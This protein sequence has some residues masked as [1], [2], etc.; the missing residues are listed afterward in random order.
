L[1]YNP[2]PMLQASLSSFASGAGVLS[3]FG[4]PTCA[5][6]SGDRSTR[7]SKSPAAAKRQK[8]QHRKSGR[9]VLLFG[10]FWELALYRAEVLEAH[11][12]TVTLPR[13]K[14]DA[15]AAIRGGS[16]DIAILSY[17]LPDK[18][19]EELTELIREYCPECPLIAISDTGRVDRR[20]GPDGVVIADEGPAALIAALR[21]AIKSN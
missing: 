9:R 10:S 20:I 2:R 15:V 18:T 5:G 17:T 6:T 13:T 19:V 16:F 4:I 8:P 7:L 12:F 1:R 11:D 3:S 14:E 21:R